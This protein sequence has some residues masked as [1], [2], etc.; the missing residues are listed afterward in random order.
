MNGEEKLYMA[1][2]W[3]SDDLWVECLK[4]GE[5]KRVVQC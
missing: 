5:K 2:Q 1:F 4:C 3:W